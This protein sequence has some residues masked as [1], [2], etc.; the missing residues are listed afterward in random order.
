[1]V[2]DKQAYLHFLIL[3]NLLPV[4]L[5]MRDFATKSAENPFF[6]TI[7]RDNVTTFVVKREKNANIL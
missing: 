7:S 1:M 2:T 3:Q 5:R 4:I 6:S